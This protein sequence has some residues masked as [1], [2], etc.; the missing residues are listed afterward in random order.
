M[1]KY[2]I[3]IALIKLKPTHNP[4]LPPILAENKNKDC[5]FVHFEKKYSMV[6]ISFKKSKKKISHITSVI[7]YNSALLYFT[8]Q[9][10]LKNIQT[11]ESPFSQDAFFGTVEADER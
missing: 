1:K 2:R 5:F 9:L 10:S 7:R 4:R 8:T 3:S 11:L 6:C